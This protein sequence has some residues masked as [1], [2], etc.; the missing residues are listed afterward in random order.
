MHL[1]P[2]IDQILALSL[3]MV[4]YWAKSIGKALYFYLLRVGV[5]KTH[6]ELP[7]SG[8]GTRC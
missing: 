7:R 5:A 8:L 1:W 6:S 2:D 4:L 3:W